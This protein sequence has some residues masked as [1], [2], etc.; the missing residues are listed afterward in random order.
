MAKTPGE[1]IDVLRDRI[2]TSEEITDED[3]EALIAPSWC[4]R[5]RGM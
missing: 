5:N 4:R 1:R 3:A 2:H